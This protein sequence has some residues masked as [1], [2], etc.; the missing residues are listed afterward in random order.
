[1]ARSRCQPRL[2]PEPT[3]LEALNVPL[4]VS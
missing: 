3:V 1:M 4:T 2:I